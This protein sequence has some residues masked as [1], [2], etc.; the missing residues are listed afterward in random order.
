MKTQQE[1]EQGNIWIAKQMGWA[2][3]PKFHPYHP[4][5]GRIY[6]HPTQGGVMW[7]KK[8]NYHCSWEDLMPVVWSILPRYGAFLLSKG[9]PEDGGAFICSGYMNA[10]VY[11]QEPIFHAHGDTDIMTTWEAITEYLKNKK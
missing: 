11:M 8:F 10:N 4:D 7:A 5:L 6:K 1:I 3:T 9:D 2:E